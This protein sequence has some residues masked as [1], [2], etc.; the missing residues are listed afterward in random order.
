MAC[1]V[2]HLWKNRGKKDGSGDVGVERGGR[3]GGAEGRIGKKV[4]FITYHLLISRKP[5]VS[6]TVSINRWYRNCSLAFISAKESML[7]ISLDVCNTTNHHFSTHQHHHCSPTSTIIALLTI[8]I[9]PT[10]TITAPPTSLPLLKYNTLSAPQ[11]TL[12][13]GKVCKPA[14]SNISHAGYNLCV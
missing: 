11:Q 5:V 13:K 4:K 12:V 8:T 7:P 9:L 14:Y 2:H 10:I 3:N 6:L 1:M